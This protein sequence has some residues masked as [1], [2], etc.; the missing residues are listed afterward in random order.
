MNREE[1]LEKFSVPTILPNSS[2]VRL[3]DV[4]GDDNS[5]VQSARVSYGAGTKSVSDD[6][7]LIRYLMRNQH[8]SPFE[9]C[10][11]KFHLKMDIGTGRQLIRHRTASLNEVSTRYSLVTDEPM[12]VRPDQWRLQSADNKQGSS[13]LLKDLP[14]VDFEG[15]KETGAM[16]ADEATIRLNE[17]YGVIQGTYTDL[18]S[19]G[20]AREQARGILP[21]ATFTEMY[22]KIDLRNLFHFLQLRLD[23]HAQLEIRMLAQAMADIVKEWVPLAWESF[24]DYVLYAKTFSKQELEIL[25][26]YLV[27]I[28]NDSTTLNKL[29]KREQKEFLEKI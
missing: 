19:M 18:I 24:E 27:S 1:L 16:W 23:S 28:P 15:L 14:E 5:I 4:M 22:W 7:N 10:E 20:V 2:M 6:R 17:A 13:G 21:L 25:K 29:S 9:Q 26:Q 11:I 3:V 12:L 8:T